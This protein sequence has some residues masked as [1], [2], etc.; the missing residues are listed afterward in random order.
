MRSLKVAQANAQLSAL[1]DAV[2]SGDDV[3]ITRRGPG[4]QRKAARAINCLQA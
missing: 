4:K 3:E 2:E 1:L